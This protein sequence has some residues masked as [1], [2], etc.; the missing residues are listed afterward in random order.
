MSQTL[1]HPVGQWLSNPKIILHPRSLS[2][3]SHVAWML[4]ASNFLFYGKPG[5][6]PEIKP[7]DAMASGG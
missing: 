2:R 1:H 3:H 7:P 6:H 5:C 4:D